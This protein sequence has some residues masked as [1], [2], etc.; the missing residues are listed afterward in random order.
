MFRG[1][2]QYTPIKNKLADIGARA[3]RGGGF[4]LG[5]CRYLAEMEARKRGLSL[6]EI[7]KIEEEG[8]NMDRFVQAVTGEYPW[9]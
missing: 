4:R 8:K 1:E 6:E 7:R 5:L 2:R 9:G 3:E